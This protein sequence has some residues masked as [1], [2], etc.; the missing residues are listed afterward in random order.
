MSLKESIIMPAAA[1]VLTLAGCYNSVYDDVPELAPRESAILEV[2]E[3]SEARTERL[4][5]LEKL[6]NEKYTESVYRLNAGDRLSVIVYGHSDLDVTALIAPDGC[7]GMALAGRIRLA[8]L[9]LDEA[10]S[11]VEAALAKYIKNPKVGISPYEIL[12]E[13]ATIAGAVTAPGMYTISDGMRLADLYAKAG[14][15]SIQV[16]N[17]KS[18]E[19]AD[20]VNSVF[21]RQGETLPVNFTDAIE[22]GMMPDN[23]Q[24]RKGDYVYIATRQDQ[25]VY[26]VGDV[27]EP[28][29]QLYTRNLGLLEFLA[30]CGWVKE[31]SWPNVI[32]I[33]GGLSHPRMYKV[34]LD[35]VLCGRKSNV[36]LE[37]GDIV[38]V[39]RDGIS[40]YNVFVRKLMPTA[41]LINMI[42]TPAAW[43][44]S[45]GT[46]L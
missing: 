18:L 39:P 41:Q 19:A 36:H 14:G 28:Q 44:T 40:E 6:E 3:D 45:L 25:M 7:I 26:L 2:S 24:L 8:G 17:G 10:S 15:S 12:S 9:T 37:A 13:T 16:Y 23:V 33:R 34:D 32:I 27:N 30:I 38:Y 20:L 42:I 31:T 46:G 22:K 1:V 11:V 43:A 5:K 35:G 29:Q 21:V 4:E